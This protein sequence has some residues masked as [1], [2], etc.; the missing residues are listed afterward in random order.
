MK[1]GIT[2]FCVLCAPLA[3]FADKKIIDR[4]SLLVR[5]LLFILLFFNSMI[6]FPQTKLS[7][8]SK[9]AIEYYEQADN[10]RVRGHYDVAI[11]L[12]EKAI[13]KDDQ[14]AEAYSRM[15]L[16]YR[17]ANNLSLCEEYYKKALSLYPTP[18]TRLLLDL[19]EL[20]L[21]MNKY[22]ESKVY[23]EKYL[24][25]VSPNARGYPLAT[26]MLNNVNFAVKSIGEAEPIEI[27]ELGDTVNQFDLQYFPVL[28]ADQKQLIFTRRLGSGPSDDEDLVISYRNESGSWGI[29]T[30]ISENINSELNEGTCTVSADGRTLIFT[31]CNGREGYGSCDLFISKKVGDNWSVPEN[32]GAQIN[33]SAWDSQPSL[34][35]DGR[36]LYFVST[37]RGGV[38]K[39]DIWVS[40][41]DEEGI[42]S[43]PQN[44]GRNINTK[45]NEISP[46]IHP[47]GQTLYFASSGH[48]GMGGFDIYYSQKEVGTYTK[49]INFGYPVNNGEDQ[50]SIFITAD[51]KQGYYSN[52]CD[53]GAKTCS[54]LY[55][56]VVPESKQVSFKSNFIAGRVLDSLT[57]QPIHATIE[58]YDVENNQLL[59]SVNSD[60][61]SGEY[62]MVLTEGANYALYVNASGYLFKSEKFEYNEKNNLE[63]IHKDVLLNA[64]TK[65]A[66]T[67]LNNVF[68]ELNS[69]K[70]DER[71]KTELTKVALFLIE[72][73][74]IKIRIEGHTD[75][76]G[77]AN[78]NQVL[79]DKR[80]KSVYEFLVNNFSLPQKSL[81]YQ[82]F[83]EKHPRYDNNLPT[84]QFKNRR[85]EFRVR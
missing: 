35:A 53:E 45:E 24:I 82:G 61:V 58:L 68:F 73:P 30:S 11:E 10:Y 75:N 27:I 40:F 66:S 25:K 9:K 67:E 44:L 5:S 49:P 70:L 43:K 59:L 1:F 42:W 48:L 71:S 2:T 17:M 34:S 36:I 64:L 33:S 20:Y 52:E 69:Y 41:I 54:K 60:S 56:F 28:T 3:N 13:Q 23:L 77:E 31:S 46:F 63:P 39:Q 79:S 50:V 22:S 29:P 51:G 21:Q 84:E 15:G 80:A 18:P 83:G 37:R 8:K 14:F 57:H 32:M 6:A 85:I 76:I 16:V 74:T 38:G 26:K 81:E 55:R 12:L 78:H 19:G 47:N 62:L 7:T 65:G 4:K 72:N